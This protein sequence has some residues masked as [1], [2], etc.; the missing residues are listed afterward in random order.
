MI[1]GT[2]GVPGF[3]A[4]PFLPRGPGSPFDTLA[5]VRTEP[6]IVVDTFA[7]DV[8]TFT[9]VDTLDFDTLDAVRTRCD[10]EEQEQNNV[11]T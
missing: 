7:R 3:P 9:K 11:R 10:P 1:P 8:D 4:N 5:V 2:P 6:D